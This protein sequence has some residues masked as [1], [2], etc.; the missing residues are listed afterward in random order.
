M[1][2]LR[3]PEPR[4]A[5]LLRADLQ[6]PCLA[7]QRDQLQQ[8]RQAEI[9]QIP[10]E[11]HARSP[12]V[13]TGVGNKLQVPDRIARAATLRPLRDRQRFAV[14]VDPRDVH[15]DAPAVRTGHHLGERR[16]ERPFLARAARQDQV[17]A[18]PRSGSRR[19][20][21]P[22]RAAAGSRPRRSRS[23]P[24]T[25][26]ATPGSSSSRAWRRRCAWRA[27][28]AG[29]RAPRPSRHRPAGCARARAGGRPAAAPPR[30]AGR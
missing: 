20:R 6:R 15:F 22:A 4:H 14:D 24:D 7:R 28:R 8:L 18:R 29:R 23:S 2:P 17:Q 3:T 11:A 21:A 19:A 25:P 26:G 5:A 12:I 16:Q 13:Y 30:R 1:P 10:S 9:G 27:A